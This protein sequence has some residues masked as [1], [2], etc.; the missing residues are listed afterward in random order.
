M[1]DTSYLQFLPHDID[2][3]LPSPDGSIVVASCTFHS[4]YMTR[5]AEPLIV[6]TT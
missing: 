4:A 5:F 1:A 3:L 6:D 2:R